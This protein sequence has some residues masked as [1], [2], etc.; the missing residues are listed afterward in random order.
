[1]YSSQ[2]DGLDLA[3]LTEY[4]SDKAKREAIVNNVKEL[5]ELKKK[6]QNLIDKKPMFFYHLPSDENVIRNISKHRN[7]ETTM[8]YLEQIITSSMRKIRIK[9]DGKLEIK[10]LL[11]DISSEV[12]VADKKQALRIINDCNKLSETISAIWKDD[13]IMPQDK[14]ITAQKKQ[15]ELILKL[16]GKKVNSNIIYYILYIL[17]P[18]IQRKMLLTLFYTHK[19]IVCGLLYDNKT[20]VNIMHK[21]GEGVDTK[22]YGKKYKNIQF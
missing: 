8:D 6:Y 20:N 3:N 9:Q 11:N 22:I 19:D 18:K 5:K 1:M 4:L 21:E 16:S 17:P 15:E 7:Y 10:D 2:F 12:T 14:Y 13:K